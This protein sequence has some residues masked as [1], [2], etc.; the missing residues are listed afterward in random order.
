MP[1]HEAS[2]RRHSRRYRRRRDRHP[3][4]RADRTHDGY[5]ARST[6][7]TGA[8]R[9]HIV[10]AFLRCADLRP[11]TP[12]GHVQCTGGGQ[13]LL[14]GFGRRRGRERFRSRLRRDARCCT[15]VST[16]R[17]KDD[18]AHLPSARR[19]H[20]PS[21]EDH[22]SRSVAKS[23]RTCANIADGRRHHH[24][25]CHPCWLGFT[26]GGSAYA[27]VV[28]RQNLRHSTYWCSSPEAGC[29]ASSTLL[30]RR[31]IDRR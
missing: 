21:Q 13:E 1:L 14:R 2:Q 30:H 17:R 4:S 5:V 27:G 22:W 3:C 7:P 15:A 10:R 25:H 19:V 20:G 31:F 26:V 24:H 8:S 11:G 6:R 12:R 18:D 9:R 23:K 29:A 16:K 28:S